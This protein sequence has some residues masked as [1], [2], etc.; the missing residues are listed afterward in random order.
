MNCHSF[1]PET[2]RSQV[3]NGSIPAPKWNRALIPIIGRSTLDVDSSRPPPRPLPN[4][5]RLFK[6]PDMVCLLFP[7]GVLYAAFYA[8]T[9]TISSLFSENFPWLTETQIGLC[10]LSVGGAGIIGAVLLGK[11]LDYQYRVTKRIFDEKRP[12]ISEKG[13]EHSGKAQKIESSS[14]EAIDF[15]IEKARFRLQ[16][17]WIIVYSITLIGY[18]WSI[19]S[20]TSIAVPLILQFI[21]KF[22]GLSNY[23]GLLETNFN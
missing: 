6:E 4:P 21:R 18:G 20:K 14:D 3:G 13:L 19:E 1:L 11:V 2:L 10:F 16:P 9:A 5:F 22:N 17:Y 12:P 7:T 15:P 23:F 8:V